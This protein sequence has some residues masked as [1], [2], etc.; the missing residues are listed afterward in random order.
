MVT[1][2]SAFACRARPLSFF[3]SLPRQRRVGVQRAPSSTFIRSHPFVCFYFPV[4]FIRLPFTALRDVAFVACFLFVPNPS[5]LACGCFRW[6]AHW[7]ILQRGKTKVEEIRCSKIL[8][9]LPSSNLYFELLTSQFLASGPSSASLPLKCV[10]AAQHPHRRHASRPARMSLLYRQRA[11]ER[12]K[13]TG[14]HTPRHALE[15]DNKLS[16]P[17]G[18][19]S[20]NFVWKHLG[21]H[22]FWFRCLH[23]L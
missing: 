22:D 17:L 20:A 19:R 7:Q 4:V 21:I 2:T 1:T 16:H 13:H 23:A 14:L 6:P 5:K 3:L 12:T 9:V 10:C 15:S 8:C 11:I 18:P